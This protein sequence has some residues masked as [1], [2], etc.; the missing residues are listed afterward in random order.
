MTDTFKALLKRL[1]KA[2]PE[3]FWF[4]IGPWDS[5]A[6]TDRCNGR[7][8]P[9]GL[10]DIRL[11]LFVMMA[12]LEFAYIEKQDGRTWEESIL[13]AIVHKFETEKEREA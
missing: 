3:R 11:W 10:E 12:E 5:Y 1:S 13:N 6:F 2:A 4:D 7:W 9:A 8:A